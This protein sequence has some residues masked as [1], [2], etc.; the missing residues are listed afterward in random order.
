MSGVTAIFIVASELERRYFLDFICLSHLWSQICF[1]FF[2]S[3]D[4]SAAQNSKGNRSRLET[5][6]KTN[7]KIT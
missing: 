7:A 5:K 1:F 3:L 2:P 6:T 4:P